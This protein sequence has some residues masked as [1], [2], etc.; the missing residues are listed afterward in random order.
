MKKLFFLILTTGAVILFTSL[1]LFSTDSES[2]PPIVEA[3]TNIENL[4]KKDIS[5][6]IITS[7][8]GNEENPCDKRPLLQT[9]TGSLSVNLAQSFVEFPF[10]CYLEGKEVSLL[11]NSSGGSTSAAASFY[12]LVGF[13]GDRK[14]FITI[15]TGTVASSAV[16]V[17]LSGGKR[18]MLPH[19]RLFLHNVS[20]KDSN[21][22]HFVEVRDTYAILD[23]ERDR[24]VDIL[25][26]ASGGKISPV[27]VSKFME[28][29]TY[30][31]PSEAIKYGLAHK[32]I[33][34]IDEVR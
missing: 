19:S 15:A 33:H 4:S 16:T 32:I 14:K 18:Y 20:I 6:N 9:L 7:D 13:Y 34:S 28:E 8:T 29:S 21:S 10:N 2:N 22:N 25:V 31:S 11:I 3:N 30:L 1:V 5:V 27:L 12:D 24:I 23:N 26:E 17:Y